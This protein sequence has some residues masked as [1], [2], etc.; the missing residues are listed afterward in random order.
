MAIEIA[1]S[2][3]AADFAHLGA[4][5]QE[6][7][8]GGARRIHVDVMD[9]R[10]VPNISVG[11]LVV[12]ALR[13]LVQAAGGTLDVHLMILEPERYLEDFRKAGA[14]A[15]TVHA[16][17]AGHLH[18][19]VQAVRAMGVAAGVALNPATPL[20]AL[21]EI[22]PL[23]DQVLLMSVDPGFGGQGFIPGSVDK[24]ARLR[25]LLD[26]RGLEGVEL[27]VDG[28]IGEGTIGAVARAGATIAVAGSAVFGPGKSI[29]MN[30]AA[31]RR[32][33]GAGSA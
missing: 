23:L 8:D 11:P 26:Q 29:S 18:R 10:F 30:L 7:L 27:A 9:G 12:A 31:L 25:Y 5:V 22:L 21:E 1:P 14:G 4:Q 2:I 33:A 20:G 16:E 3:L 24:I 19:T 6:A 32:E 17:A 15:L 13:P 28:G